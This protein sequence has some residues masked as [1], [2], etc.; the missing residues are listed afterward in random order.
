MRL[1]V[2][3]T[4]AISL[5]TG[6]G[7]L[8]QPGERQPRWELGVTVVELDRGVDTQSLRMALTWFVDDPE[9]E[10]LYIVLTSE[11]VAPTNT[12]LLHFD[13]PVDTLPPQEALRCDDRFTPPE[14]PNQTCESESD[15][16][17]ELQ[18]FRGY[19]NGE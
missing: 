6:C 13:L 8:D 1:G 16:P 10:G 17:D 18:C 9:T 15:C 14:I 2:S 19:C 12:D 7:T 11:D 3:V 4:L 5:L